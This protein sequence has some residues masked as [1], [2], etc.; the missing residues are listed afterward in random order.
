M[1]S[2][3]LLLADSN[4]LNNIGEFRG[5]KIAE[6]EVKSCQSRRIAMTEVDSV[7]EG[8][9]VVACLDSIAADIIKTTTDPN[10]AGRAIEVYYNQMLFKLIEKVDEANGKLAFGVLAP[11]F[12]TNLPEEAKRA[13]NHTYKL[14]KPTPLQNIWFTDYLKEVNAGADGVHLT[15][16]SAHRYIQAI[17]DLF[18]QVDAATG[19]GP[20]VLDPERVEQD[21][22]AG[23]GSGMDWA[24]EVNQT[25]NEAVVVLG[26]PAEDAAVTPPS[27]TTTML[28][29][30][31]LLPPSRQMT[32]MNAAPLGQ[33]MGCTQSRLMQLAAYPNLSVPLQFII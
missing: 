3:L 14:M 25:D 33:S 27:R 30:L 29:A 12:W 10:D 32:M 1:M 2:R 5:R 13:M 18:V 21:G 28:S 22:Q 31:I 26:P 11:L 19:L 23:A 4:F 8:I 20:V 24:E 15:K 9:V 7:E 6:L 16:R 17:L